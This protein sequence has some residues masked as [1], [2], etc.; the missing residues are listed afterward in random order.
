MSNL[1]IQSATTI[2]NI[3]S[4]RPFIRIGR[5]KCLINGISGVSSGESVL[6]NEAREILDI[7][8]STRSL[9]ITTA[10]SYDVE[11]KHYTRQ[12]M[13]EM[14]SFVNIMELIDI[15]KAKNIELEEKRMRELWKQGTISNEHH[16]AF[17][18]RLPGSGRLKR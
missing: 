1:E 4:S 17:E 5:G 2:Y 14:Q 16:N 15:H 8:K 10:T 3:G 13:E 9:S 12:D 7:Y 6:L 18:R 11:T